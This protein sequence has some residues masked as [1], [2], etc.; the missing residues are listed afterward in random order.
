MV[1]GRELRPPVDLTLPL[2]AVD[3]LVASEDVTSLLHDLRLAH[4]LARNVLSG[5]QQHQREYCDRRAHGEPLQPGASVYFHSPVPPA[6]I[7]SRF[8][9]ELSGPC[10]VEQVLLDKTCR[11]RDPGNPDMHSFSVHFNKLKPATQG[12]PTLPSSNR[13]VTSTEPP[14]AAVNVEI[15]AEGAA[16][17]EVPHADIEDSVFLMDGDGVGFHR[18]DDSRKLKAANGTI[19]RSLGVTRVPVVIDGVPVFHDFVAPEEIPWEAIIG[20][21]FLKQFSFTVDFDRQLFRCGNCE[22]PLTVETPN[23]T[24]WDIGLIDVSPEDLN[25]QIG[26]LLSASKQATTSS[27]HS[28]FHSIISKCAAAFAWKGTTFGRSKLLDHRIHTGSTLPIRQHSR[29]VPV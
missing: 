2:T 13:V 6:S 26:S 12:M 23:E 3:L 22:L 14:E 9:K 29:R 5:C 10:I 11:I 15:A 27:N 19:L 1:I 25:Y 24:K 28:Q 7:S 18:C 16:S 4:Q 17:T 21:D 8:H 20:C